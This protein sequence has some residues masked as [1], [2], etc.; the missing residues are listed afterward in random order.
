[1]SPERHERNVKNRADFDEM[2]RGRSGTFE[3]D[4]NMTTETMLG[5]L[6]EYMPRFA[7]F[8]AAYERFAGDFATSIRQALKHG[9]QADG[10]D[11]WANIH[12]WGFEYSQVKVPVTIW[13]GDLDDD[14]EVQYGAYNHSRLPGSKFVELEG[15]GHVDIMVELQEQILNSALQD[16]ETQSKSN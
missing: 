3:E 12:P 2:V 11:F 5:M 8:E 14:V 13:H 15:L 6:R 10:D 9:P 1:M 7:N 16:L 4:Q